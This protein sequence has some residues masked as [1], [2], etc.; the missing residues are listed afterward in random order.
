MESAALCSKNNDDGQSLAGTIV[1]YLL[2]TSPDIPEIESV[3][4]EDTPSP[5]NP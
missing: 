5:L 3:I 2:P 4:L 1:D